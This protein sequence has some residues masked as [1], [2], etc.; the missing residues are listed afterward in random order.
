M[1][2]LLLPI[3]EIID[4]KLSNKIPPAIEQSMATI[5]NAANNNEVSLF[6][7]L[8][9]N[10]RYVL[11][12]I[13]FIYPMILMHYYEKQFIRME[14][15]KRLL[16]NMIYTSKYVPNKKFVVLVDSSF[17]HILSTLNGKSDESTLSGSYSATKMS[18]EAQAWQKVDKME[19]MTLRE[20][21]EGTIEGTLEVVPQPF[22]RATSPIAPVATKRAKSTAT[23]KVFYPRYPVKSYLSVSPLELSTAKSQ[24]V[25]SPPPFALKDLLQHYDCS[26]GE[27]QERLFY[28]Q[29]HGLNVGNASAMESERK[30]KGGGIANGDLEF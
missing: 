19:N 7:K 9:N 14:A 1:D 23:Q 26:F 24:P 27:T 18:S 28:G 22:I 29:K 5:R 25:T 11:F 20:K 8:D 2:G 30:R 15:Y 3:M 21:E 16:K 10:A 13:Y 12:Y 6:P 4:S 17:S